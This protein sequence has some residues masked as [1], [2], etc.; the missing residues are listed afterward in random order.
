MRINKGCEIES[1]KEMGWWF[2]KAQLGKHFSTQIW[3]CLAEKRKTRTTL[4]SKHLRLIYCSYVLLRPYSKKMF[5]RLVTIWQTKLHHFCPNAQR[6]GTCLGQG[7][8]LIFASF[9][10]PKEGK[11]YPIAIKL[12]NDHKTCQTH[13]YMPNSHI[14][15]QL[16]SFLGPPKFTQIGFLVWKLT[17]WQPWS[18]FR[19]FGRMDPCVNN[20]FICFCESSPVSWKEVGKQIPLPSSFFARQT[21]VCQLSRLFT[22]FKLSSSK[23]D[24]IAEPDLEGKRAWYQ[25]TMM[26]PL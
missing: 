4:E 16:F 5:K 21:F 18:G 1:A 19:V 13:M 7:C 22:H 10:I 17:I 8:Q 15:Y 12:T 25:P 20:R 11:I 24:W 9:N 26:D 23:G 3:I 6:R 2:S 14:I